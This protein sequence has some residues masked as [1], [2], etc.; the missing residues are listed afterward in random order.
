MKNEILWI[1][2]EFELGAITAF[3][4]IQQIKAKT[5]KL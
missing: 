5:K 2:E 1:I 4:C 3:E